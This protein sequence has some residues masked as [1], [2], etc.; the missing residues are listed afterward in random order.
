MRCL[1]HNSAIL[2]LSDAIDFDCHKYCCVSHRLHNNY[3]FIDTNRTC[4]LCERRIIT[5]YSRLHSPKL[6]IDPFYKA[7]FE[8]HSI[9]S[10]HARIETEISQMFLCFGN[11]TRKMKIKSRLGN[12]RRISR[13]NYLIIPNGVLIKTETNAKKL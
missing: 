4:V 13:I 3:M 5:S 12:E 8:F 2:L 6:W 7:Y 10:K 11:V 9:D 1:L